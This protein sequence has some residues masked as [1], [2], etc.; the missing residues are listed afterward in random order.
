MASVHADPMIRIKHPDKFFIDGEWIRPST[1]AKLELISPNSEECFMSVAEGREADI[2]RAVSAA[3]KAFDHGPWPHLSHQDR[4]VK[5]R[6][7][8]CRL[9]DRLEEL[10]YVHTEQMGAL[11]ASAERIAAA[12]LSKLDYYAGLAAT[13]HWTEERNAADGTLLSVPRGGDEGPAGRRAAGDDAIAVVVKEPVGVV[14][15]I[16]PWNGPLALLTSKLAP[17]L[18]AG[19]TLIVKPS[20][21]TPLEA[22]ILAECA[23]AAGFP[24]GVINLVCAQREVSDYLVRRTG[25]DKVSFTGS[26][27][28]GRRIASV[29]GERIARVS[30]ELGGK[31][32]AIVLDDADPD[33]VAASLTGGICSL[34]GQICAA[35]SR[36]VVSR[37]RHDDFVDALAEKFRALRIGHSRDSDTQLGPLAMKRQLER[38][39]GYIAQGRSDGA[40]LV[41]GGNRPKA[42]RRGYFIEPTLF[43]NVDNAIP[44]AQEEIF[45]PVLTVIKYEDEPDAIRIANDSIFGLNGAV[46]TNDAGR[47]YEIMRR[48]RTGTITQNG[49]KVSAG[50]PFGGFKQSG[51]GRENGIEG[52]EM[53]LEKKTLHLERRPPNF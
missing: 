4:A 21:E 1:A 47:A 8:A 37:R 28:A 50:L 14:A 9:R 45:G 52:L 13:Y 15:I 41:T 23:D 33:T 32:A 19:C 35:L 29:C 10:V 5:L 27:A 51:I 43:A 2:D 48:V 6:E 16:T 12:A 40:T 25:V 46:F 53:Y 22:Y 11:V 31:S 49:F 3:R 18:L 7:L 30:L 36:V 24:P 44:L 34:S 42:L 26:T 17:A 38:V 20:P 39:E